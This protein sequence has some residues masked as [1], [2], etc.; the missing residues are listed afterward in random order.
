MRLKTLALGLVAAGLAG[1]AL[2]AQAET[3]TFSFNPTGGGAVG[4][5][6]DLSSF[7]MAQGNVLTKGG[8]NGGGPL[9]PG[10]TYTT[11][12]QANLG[13][14][15]FEDGVGFSNDGAS[16]KFFTAVANFQETV[17]SSGLN[18]N[19][20]TNSF[21][22]GAGGSFKMCAQTANGVSLTGVG[23]GCAGNGILSGVFVSGSASQTADITDPL[24]NLDNFNTNNW[25][26]V[27]TV[28]TTGGADLRL[29]ITSVDAGYF[30]DLL[31]DDLLTLGLV[32]T[33]LITP[34][35]QVNPSRRFSEGGVTD[36][37][38]TNVGATNGVT[39]P[40]FITQGDANGSFQRVPEPGS[41]ALAG[42][43]LGL[44]AYA[45]RRRG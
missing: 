19:D 18:G 15:L 29:L 37:Y 35:S 2:T 28:Q 44:M 12:Y 5:I 43:A 33:S 17:S 9:P 1:V 34:F 21:T 16:G 27:Q 26:G 10:T 39:G 45:A 42:L 7:D 25:S 30:P 40:D 41:L 20:L 32:N 11:L 6:T 36:D 3:I 4:A 13:S 22:I 38:D 23:F 24:V 31:V 8:V 14:F